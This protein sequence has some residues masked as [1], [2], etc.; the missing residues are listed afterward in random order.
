MACGDD[1]EYLI[2]HANCIARRL[3]GWRR[4]QAVTNNPALHQRPAHQP[5]SRTRSRSPGAP[6]VARRPSLLCL[7]QP[8]RALV[9][10]RLVW[11]TC[12]PRPGRRRTFSSSTSRSTRLQGRARGQPEAQRGFTGTQYD[13]LPSGPPSALLRAG[14][15]TGA[16]NSLMTENGAPIENGDFGI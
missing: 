14:T 9:D 8:P 11:L 15:G 16:V 2:C 4:N 1:F 6:T 3:S 5:T 13:N 10:H 12:C 7:C